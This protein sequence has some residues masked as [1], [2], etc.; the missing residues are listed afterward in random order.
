MLGVFRVGQDFEQVGVT[1]H[2]AA[3]LRRTGIR[4]RETSRMLECRVGWQQL[5]KHYFMLP[6]VAEVVF[7][8]EFPPRRWSQVG[9]RIAF[10]IECLA[11]LVGKLR[12]RRAVAGAG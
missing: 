3:V 6:T 1:P 10:L 8:T 12:V 5:L 2:A 11:P 9:H 7:V 4:T